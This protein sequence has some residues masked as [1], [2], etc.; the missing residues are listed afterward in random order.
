MIYANIVM[1]HRKRFAINHQPWNLVESIWQR[2]HTRRDQTITACNRAAFQGAE[3]PRWHT[4]VDY[5]ID[6]NIVLYEVI[7]ARNLLPRLYM[8]LPTKQGLHE[9]C[10][11]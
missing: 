6:V 3:S 11:S 8:T 4:S 10:Q 9:V 2:R 5:C 1:P 7:A